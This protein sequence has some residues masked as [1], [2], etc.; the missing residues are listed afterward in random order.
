M[1][2]QPQKYGNEK[3]IRFKKKEYEIYTSAVKS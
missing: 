1:K 2:I 3:N